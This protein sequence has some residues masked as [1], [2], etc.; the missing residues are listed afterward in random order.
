MK[1]QWTTNNFWSD[2]LVSKTRP[3]NFF[4]IFAKNILWDKTP[5]QPGFYLLDNRVGEIYTVFHFRSRV[6]SG[7]SLGALGRGKS[8]TVTKQKKI[9]APFHWP[10]LKYHFMTKNIITK[11][12]IF[13]LHVYLYNYLFPQSSKNISNLPNRI[14]FIFMV[15]FVYAVYTI[16]KDCTLCTY[17][18]LPRCFSV[19]SQIFIFTFR[20]FWRE[21][22][23]FFDKQIFLRN[24]FNFWYFIKIWFLKKILFF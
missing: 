13:Q 15:F 6:F 10:K 3:R 17:G 7:I 14:I 12:Y 8:V 19:S 9:I 16:L 2:F 5:L 24:I 1:L 20:Y 11:P 21:N 23:L 22:L 4:F 18:C